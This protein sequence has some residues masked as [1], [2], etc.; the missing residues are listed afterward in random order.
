[1][2]AEDADVVKLLKVLTFLPLEK[3][4]E[5][6]AEVRANPGAR[7]AQ[8]ALAREL[9]TLVHGA[10][11]CEDAMRASEIMFGGGLEG[12]SEAVFEDVVGEVPTSR[13]DRSRLEGS[14]LPL[15][16][17]FVQAGLATSKGQARKDIEGGGGYVNN[18]RVSEPTRVLTTRDLLLGRY[19]LLR[20]GKRNYAVLSADA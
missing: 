20:K 3:I 1:M 8:R 13:V 18:V 14:G 15:V 4:A 6:E 12:V 2:Q 10:R 11:A 9:T 7:A 17:A 16:E 19:I 5:L